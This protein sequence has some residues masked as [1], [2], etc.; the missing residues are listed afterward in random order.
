VIAREC[1]AYRKQ[2][3]EVRAEARKLATDGI[4]ATM[5]QRLAR[6]DALLERMERSDAELDRLAHGGAALC[7]TDRWQ[8]CAGSEV[9][10]KTA[11]RGKR[12]KLVLNPWLNRD[13]RW[14]G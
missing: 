12:R 3:E 7:D 2:L 4:A 10:K 5:D 8:Q 11:P 6:L 9:K 1:V 14:G 13:R